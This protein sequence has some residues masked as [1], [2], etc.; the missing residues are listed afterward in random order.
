METLIGLLILIADIFAIVKILQSSADTLKKLL[1]I[2]IIILLPVI[3]LVI[4]YLIGPG[5]KSG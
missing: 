4:W 2:L 5:G 1:W 3:G